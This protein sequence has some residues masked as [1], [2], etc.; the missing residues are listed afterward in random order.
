M[1]NL[2]WAILPSSYLKVLCFDLLYLIKRLKIFIGSSDTL[3]LNVILLY[4]YSLPIRKK[5]LFCLKNN[6]LSS[7]NKTSC[8]SRSN[9]L[10][11]K[12]FAIILI[13]NFNF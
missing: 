1:Y 6:L 12:S 3:T 8:I 4:R 10:K 7:N 2:L 5:K 13:D 9:Q 11:K